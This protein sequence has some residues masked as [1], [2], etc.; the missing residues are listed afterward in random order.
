MLYG[1][2]D[3]LKLQY[4]DRLIKALTGGGESVNFSRLEGESCNL[5]DMI[6]L[7]QTMPFFAE[8]RCILL[9]ESGF[10]QSSNDELAA[11][12]EAVPET[13]VLIFVEKK[14]NKSTKS[15]KTIGKYGYA[16]DFSKP[17]EETLMKWIGARL[18]REKK[19]MAPEAW[20]EFFLRSGENMENMEREFEKLVMY[21]F[22]RDRIE[23]NDVRAITV[24]PLNDRVFDLV[25]AMA[26]RDT[27]RLMDCY[28][29]LVTA[30]EQPLRILSLL[31]RQF[32]QM[33]AVRQMSADHLSDQTIG[34]KLSIPPYIVGKI[35]RSSRAYRQEQ[36]RQLLAD[37]SD[38]EERIKTG[39]ISDRMGV[40]LLM[41]QYA[42]DGY[43]NDGN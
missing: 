18:A 7:A 20:R 43:A 29:D 33:L 26:D 12:L 8:Y 38:V 16:C 3:Y 22:D 15:F 42:N 17:G 21:C 14:V 1:E 4:R 39:R 25:D 6:D 34:K 32:M 23:L 13:A 27:R 40:E 9:M 30:K 24:R 11:Y 2:E 19:T 35:R 10:F 36:I 41:M 37:A 5:K 31:E 28:A